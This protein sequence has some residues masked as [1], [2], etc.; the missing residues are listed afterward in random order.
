MTVIDAT[1]VKLAFQLQPGAT[2]TDIVLTAATSLQDATT[3]S[4]L[5]IYL[6]TYQSIYLNIC[7]DTGVIKALACANAPSKR[8]NNNR[9]N[10]LSNESCQENL[11]ESSSLLNAAVLSV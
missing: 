3:V 5:Q 1:T 7:L 4:N 6:S 11:S 2:A 10:A 8:R 9:E